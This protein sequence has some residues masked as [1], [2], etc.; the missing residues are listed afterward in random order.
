MISQ[1][2]NRPDNFNAVPIRLTK[3]NTDFFSSFIF[4]QVKTVLH[5]GAAGKI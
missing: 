4:K 2:E 3:I 5:C 1:S